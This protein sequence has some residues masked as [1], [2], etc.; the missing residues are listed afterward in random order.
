M[1]YREPPGTTFLN[2]EVPASLVLPD[3]DPCH[4]CEWNSHAM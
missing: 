4:I 3:I 2:V 1:P